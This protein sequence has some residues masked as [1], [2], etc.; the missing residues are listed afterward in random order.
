MRRTIALLIAL[1]VITSGISAFAVPNSV[2]YSSTRDFLTVLDNE[3]IRYSYDGIN[4]DNDERVKVSY[5][6]DDTKITVIC[7]FKEDTKSCSMR[8]WNF[9]DYEASDANQVIQTLDQLNS[10][11]R[12]VKFYSDA[13]DNS[14]TVS[15]DAVFRN[16]D[17]GEIC[18][19]CLRHIVNICDDC[20]TILKPYNKNA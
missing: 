4:N 16:N 12:W 11:Y 9:I 17:V 7:F 2:A 20:Y 10:K 6:L 14:V 13:S 15:L 5:S 19:E 3:S 8:V 1:L 18:R